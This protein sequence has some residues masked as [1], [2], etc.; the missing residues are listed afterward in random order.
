MVQSKQQP[1]GVSPEAQK[2][3]FK[4]GDIELVGNHVISTQVLS[5]LYKDKIGKEITV[6]DLFAIVQNIT[7]FY[8]NNGYIISRAILP[9]QHV[10]A[11]P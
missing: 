7:N 4:L 9:P 6:A 10:K 5:L 8:R 1:Q 2:I 11:V 3:K